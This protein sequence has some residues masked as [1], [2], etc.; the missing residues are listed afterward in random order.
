MQIKGWL[1]NETKYDPLRRLT[2]F[3]SLRVESNAFEIKLTH[4]QDFIL[5]IWAGSEDLLNSGRL[6]SRLVVRE[7]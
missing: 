3:E 4:S 6:D 2:R 1:Q 5:E 7:H